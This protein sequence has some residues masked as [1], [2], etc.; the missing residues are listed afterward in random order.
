VHQE[1]GQTSILDLAGR[2]LSKSPTNLSKAYGPHKGP[3]RSRLTS[4][5]ARG[6]AM[7]F[8]DPLGPR[9]TP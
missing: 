1:R 9:S 7:T 4:S 3:L 5:T 8:P 6:L 2:F